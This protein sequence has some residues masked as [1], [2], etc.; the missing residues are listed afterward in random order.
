MI[1]EQFIKYN[2]FLISLCLSIF[3]VFSLF[4]PGLPPS[5]D[6][7]YHVIR[8]FEFY[9]TLQSGSVF[10]VWAQHL[11]FGYGVPLFNYV[12]P[13]PNYAASIFHFFGFSFV[14][15]FKLNLIFASILGSITAYMLGFQK[16][17]KWGGLL[18]SV[19]Y[20]YAPYHFL[21]IY[22]RGSVGE[23]WALAFFP[24]PL[25]FINRIFAKV[26]TTDLLFLSISLSLII[27]SH[28]ILSLMYVFFVCAYCI[29]VAIVTRKSFITLVYLGFG[30]IMSLLLSASFVVPALLE[31]KYVI[32]LNMFNYKDHF[33]ELF[34]LLIPSWGH[35]FSGIGSTGDQMSLQVG[36]VNLL[37]ILVISAC[38]IFK[39]I[40]NDK[41]YVVF[42]LLS[43]FI[44]FFLMTNY[45]RSVWDVFS[46]MGYF[47]F[48]WRLL[49]LVILCCAILAGSLAS[50][51]KSKIIYTLVILLLLL[52]TYGYAKVPYMMDRSDEYYTSNSTFIYGT[53]SIGN[54]FQTKW[55][56]PQANVSSVSAALQ[57]GNGT[58]RKDILSP[59]R[60]KYG[61]N[62]ASEDKIIFYTAY[63]PGWTVFAD[64]KE[65]QGKEEKGLIVASLKG[66]EKII[67]LKLKDTPVRFIS[68]LV[69]SVA[70]LAIIFILATYTMLQ[71]RYDN[72]HR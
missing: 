34:Q 45:S 43:F 10:P 35:G 37:L 14:D 21:D 48:P 60:Q 50:I 46:P 52:S 28:N 16:F 63:F 59:T 36:I 54:A 32:G 65:I 29:F 23:V 31:K 24:L 30:F 49:S 12:Y 18:T 70:W 68:K 22:V 4:Q 42:F 51:F 2:T 53:N 61:I 44:L 6:G 56:P 66:N 9:N 25:F 40:K 1:L 5:H 38:F 62:L 33:P 71:F 39:K 69:S 27:F 19:F 13:L 15:S 17:G 41:A 3:S 67:E 58:I 57:K 47:Q 26:R 20:T 72:R 11:N 8:F 7:E 64:K 55:L